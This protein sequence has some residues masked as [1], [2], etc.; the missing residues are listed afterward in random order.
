MWMDAVDL[1]DF[2]ASDQGRVARI[3][4]RRRIREVWPDVKGQTVMGV[5]YATPYLGVFR[6]EAERIVAI[7]P[8]AQGVLHWPAEGGGLTTL[9][10]EA[11]LPF[12]DLSVDRLLLVHT[13]EC[14]EQVRPLLR[15]AWRVLA[16]GGRLMVVVPNRRGLWA[17]FERTPFGHGLPYS[18]GQ[19]SRLL[20]E[21]LFTP[22]LSRTA[23]FVPPLTNRFLLSSAGAFENIGQRWFSTFAGVILMEAAKQIYAASPQAM[24]RQRRAWVTVRPTVSGP[25]A[26]HR[27]DHARSEPL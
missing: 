9:T 25:S 3:M 15:E 27:A 4:I 2:Y 21:T 8:A 6:G 1:R 13:L 20:R 23:L 16:G 5:G 22:L 17:R 14:T 19:L 7:M 18:P 24:V 11:D 10:E 12:P 26:S